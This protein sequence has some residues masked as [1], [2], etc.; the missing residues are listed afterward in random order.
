MGNKWLTIFTVTIV[1]Q[2][3]LLRVPEG[4]AFV[5]AKGW[6]IQALKSVTRDDTTQHT[7]SPASMSSSRNQQ[8]PTCHVFSFPM[9]S[10][11]SVISISIT[12]Y[13]QGSP[14][15]TAI[16]TFRPWHLTRNLQDRSSTVTATCP[17]PSE[18]GARAS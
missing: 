16:T 14:R 3:R 18:A 15:L 17:V 12:T 8:V 2:T 10:V 11:V 5:N 1:G 7:V 9:I 4:E 6:E 13:H